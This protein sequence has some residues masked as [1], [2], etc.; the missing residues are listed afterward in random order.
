MG[1]RMSSRKDRIKFTLTRFLNF[2]KI[3]L[4]NKRG[5]VGLGIIGLFAFVALFA[6]FLTPYDSLGWDPNRTNIPL[7]SSEAAPSWLR[8]LPVILGGQ[9]TLSEN[10]ILINDSSF[11][12]SEWR[13][14][15]GEWNVSVSADVGEAVEVTHYAE[16]GYPPSTGDGCLVISFKRNSSS[17]YGN[18]TIRLYKEFDYPYSGPPGTGRMVG[19]VTING[20]E[21]LEERLVW[22]YT[23]SDYDINETDVYD[24]N[25]KLRFFVE[26]VGGGYYNLWPDLSPGNRPALF[27]KT[28][29]FVVSNEWALSA[30]LIEASTIF[31]TKARYRFGVEILLSDFYTES[32]NVKM[33]VRIDNVALTLLGTGWGILGTDYYGRDIFSQL[34]YGSRISLYVGLLSAV[35]SVGIGLIIGLAAGYLGRT[36]DEIMMRVTDILL[37]LPGLPLLIVLFAVLGASIENLIIL[38]G[39]LGWMGFAKVVRSQVLSIRERPYIEAAKAAGSGKTHIIVTHILPN[40]MGLVYVSLATAVPG[41]IVSEAALSWLGFADPR[42]M[43]WGRM[44]SEMQ[45]HHAVTKLWWVLP[46]GLSIAAVCISFILLGYALDEVLN[47]KLRLRR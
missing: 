31:S 44:L 27:N 22:N 47:P 1:E 35:L 5:I 24:V 40:V 4:R 30:P 36:A 39:L 9:P 33:E 38:M 41:A 18:I 29:Y 26:R 20:T 11:S 10:V 3:F 21:H 2:L 45:E 23:K 8:N 7:A 46:P 37:V 12:S 43:S 25:G 15:T 42:R 28:G 17:T 19:A 16:G 32:E 13:W 34:I 14:P 6:P